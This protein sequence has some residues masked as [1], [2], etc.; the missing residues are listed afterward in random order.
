MNTKKPNDFLRWQR[1]LR[2]WSL[3]RVADELEKLGGGTDSKQVGK[4]ERG[5]SRPSP[6]YREKLCILFGNTADRLGFI[7]R[8]VSE[9]ENASLNHTMYVSQAQALN[10]NG[11][12]SDLVQQQSIVLASQLGDNAMTKFNS[13]RRGFLE[14]ALASAS[15]ASLPYGTQ[16]TLLGADRSL[17]RIGSPCVARRG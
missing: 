2:G 17:Q 16:H 9:S 15:I 5:V 7:E 13:S 12:S 11:N 10:V 1:E 14:A 6:F 4:W 8:S 3:Q